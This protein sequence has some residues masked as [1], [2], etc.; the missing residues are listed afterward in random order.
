MF[1]FPDDAAWDEEED[2][3]TFTLRFGEYEGRVFV[4][5][6][7]FQLRL[8][9]RPTPAQCVEYFH[10]NRSDFERTAE[11][12]VLAR[13]LDEDANIHLTGRDLRT[14]RR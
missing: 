2:A 8:G 13:Q 6:R 3:V 14:L 7:L 9:S 1:A 5:R 12:R 11:A 4:P 10:L